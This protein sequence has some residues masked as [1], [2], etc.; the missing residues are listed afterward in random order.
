LSGKQ[1]NRL[2]KKIG[3]AVLG[4]QKR[5][6]KPHGRR[7][8]D[9]IFAYEKGIHRF[10]KLGR[11]GGIRVVFYELVFNSKLQRASSRILMCAPNFCSP[12]PASNVRELEQFFRHIRPWAHRRSDQ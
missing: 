1:R 3:S 6:E 9:L 11:N 5:A 2:L 7:C 8:G 12:V 10:L 4:H